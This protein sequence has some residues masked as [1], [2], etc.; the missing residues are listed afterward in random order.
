M[1]SVN[2]L[3]IR[4]KKRLRIYARDKHKCVYCG[5]LERL[6]LDHYRGRSNDASNLITACLSCNSAK[7]GKSIRAWFALLRSRG[8]NTNALRM[9]IARALARKL[10]EISHDTQSRRQNGN[11]TEVRQASQDNP[12]TEAMHATA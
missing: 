5:A 1:S 12:S 11:A 6:S 2:G 10:P 9:R 7:Q 4:K 8:V 3:W